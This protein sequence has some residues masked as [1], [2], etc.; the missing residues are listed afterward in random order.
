MSEKMIPLTVREA[1]LSDCKIL[2]LLMRESIKEQKITDVRG[3]SCQD[4]QSKGFGNVPAFHIFVSELSSGVINGYLLYI[5]AFSSIVGRIVVVKDIY[6]T[7]EYRRRGTA[8]ALWK[9]LVQK[10]SAEG[11]KR[12]DIYTKAPNKFLLSIGACDGTVSEYSGDLVYEIKKDAMEELI[13]RQNIPSEFI[14]REA[15][16]KDIPDIF[17]CL[18]SLHLYLGILNEVITD[19]TVLIKEGFGK[20]PLFKSYVAERNG[21][22]VGYTL[23]SIHLWFRCGPEVYMEDLYVSSECR[24]TGIG[25]A[26]WASVLKETLKIGGKRCT[27]IVA[28]ENKSNNHTGIVKPRVKVLMT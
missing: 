2:E 6:V 25:T 14:L 21:S 11:C 28:S 8:T 9:T 18:K 5:Y 13:K 15:T 1:R 17:E 3:L 16:A 19:E 12:C 22:I 24:G 26:L 4:L 7:P 27:H 23:F 10:V 20:R